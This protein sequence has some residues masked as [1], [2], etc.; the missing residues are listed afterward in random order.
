[1]K[2]NSTT[3]HSTLAIPTGITTAITTTTTIITTP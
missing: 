1:M 3:Y 2:N